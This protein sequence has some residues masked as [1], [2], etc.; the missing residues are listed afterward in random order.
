MNAHEGE[1]YHYIYRGHRVDTEEH[2]EKTSFFLQ[3]VTSYFGLLKSSPIRSHL[4]YSLCGL[5]HY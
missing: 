1:C 3:R 4:E 2:R 5:C